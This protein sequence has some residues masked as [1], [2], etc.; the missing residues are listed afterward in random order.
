M[1]SHLLLILGVVVVCAGQVVACSSDFTSCTESRTCINSGGAGVGGNDDAADAGDS[2]ASAGKSGSAGGNTAGDGG[3][4]AGDGGNTAGDGGEGGALF[5]TPALFGACSGVGKIACDG[6]ASAQRLAC[7]GS[8]WQAGTTC[9]SGQLC[10]SEDSKC[11]PKIEECADAEP[12]DIVCRGDAP[13]TCGP[14]LVTAEL[15]K[16]CEG[17]CKDGVCVAPACG[18]GKTQDGETCDDGN[19]LPGDGC[20]PTCTAEPVALALGIESTCVL[21]STGLVKCWGGNTHGQLGLGDISNRG[22]EPSE[23]PSKLKPVDLGK[24][25]TAKAIAAKGWMTCALLD[26]GE[27]KC[28]GDNEYGQLGTGDHFDRGDGPG[29]M[30]DALKGVALGAGQTATAIAAGGNHTCA[31]LENGEL[32]CWGW[33]FYGELGQ[34]NADD[35]ALPPPTPVKLGRAVKSVSAS[36]E[37]TTCVL[38]DNADAKCWGLRQDLSVPDSAEK[39]ASA[40][41]G[42]YLDE[43]SKLPPLNFGG[44][45]TAKQISAGG[46]GTCAILSDD[47][48]KC[49]GDGSEEQLGNFHGS[50]SAGTPEAL[51]ALLPVDLGAGK[52]PKFVALEVGHNCVLL[53]SGEMECFGWNADGV[54]GAGTDALYPFETDSLK[55]V[56]LGG[57]TAI[58]IATGFSHTC[59]ILNDG[60]LKCWG[61]NSSGQ[62]GLGDMRTRGD[63]GGKLATDTTVDLSF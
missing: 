19:L 4:T 26:N 10:N 5:E 41:I 37:Q 40:G 6:A 2:S 17:A 47:S 7:V 21:S 1:N 29:E 45:R 20:S 35:Y 57:K 61:G 44:G 34:E 14:D 60:T 54:L 56:Y 18:D 12:G 27:V 49:W 30:G 48:L 3:N 52:K 32:K 55:P 42:D 43:I 53:V 51:A 58:Q 9:P 39:N 50:S 13:L 24:G 15:G 16:Q 38:L 33:N 23:L 8:R 22:D 25:R 63:T 46:R 62:L 59:A 36:L 28:W 31:V 11:T